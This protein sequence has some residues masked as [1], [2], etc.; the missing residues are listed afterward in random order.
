MF[1]LLPRVPRPSRPAVR[2]LSLEHACALPD[3]TQARVDD[4][5]RR[6]CTVCMSPA[7]A[8]AGGIYARCDRQPRCARSRSKRDPPH[9]RAC[10]RR[11]RLPCKFRQPT[12]DG[13]RFR[14]STESVSDANILRQ[15]RLVQRSRAAWSD[16]SPNVSQASGKM[17]T[18]M[19]P[20]DPT[21]F[22]LIHRRLRERF[23]HTSEGEK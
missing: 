7:A 16:S 12:T 13:P 3:D 2:A 14:W 4:D 21:L 23:M 11:S 8:A 20:R 15:V 18:S 9:L 10:T 22:R 19:K 17:S 5:P 6:P 1:L